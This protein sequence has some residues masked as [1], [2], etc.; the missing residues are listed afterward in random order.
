M[1]KILII[2]TDIDVLTILKLI[3]SANGFAVKAVSKPENIKAEIASFEPGIILLG[4]PHADENGKNLCRQIK[5]DPSSG[6]TPL[7]IFSSDNGEIDPADYKA[8]SFIK[9]PFDPD[10]LVTNLRLYL[11]SSN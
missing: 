6:Q 8:D 4:I 9:K 7:L 3:L 11:T 1:Y 5:S 10:H 2:D